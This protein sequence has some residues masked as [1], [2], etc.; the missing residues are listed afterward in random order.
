MKTKRLVKVTITLTIIM[1][2]LALTEPTVH[3]E[4]QK[5]Q[6]LLEI[7][8]SSELANI[9]NPTTLKLEIDVEKIRQIR[10]AKRKAE[11]E[12]K[13][14]EEEQRK[15]EEAK[16]IVYDGM[17]IQQLSDKLNRTLNSDLKGK[18]ELFAK[19]SVDLGIDPYLAVAISMHETGCKWNCSRLVKTCN[20]VGGMKGSPGCGGGAYARFSSLDE[21]IRA[22]MNNLYKNYTSKGLTTPEAMSP[23]YAGSTTWASQVRTYMNEIKAK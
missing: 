15:A 7:K 11:E 22:Y 17:N 4:N 19:M 3:A 5:P 1:T 6:D 16:K 9:G 21:G 23:K 8:P 14:I 10:I 2:V 18:G 20:N 12:R 13:R